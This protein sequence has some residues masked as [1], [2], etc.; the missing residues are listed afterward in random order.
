MSTE[1]W[2]QVNFSTVSKIALQRIS[3]PVSYNP[4]TTAV[5]NVP[6]SDMKTQYFHS[7]K[8]V[9]ELLLFVVDVDG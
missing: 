8:A 2:P 1:K 7:L 3:P 5:L 4:P 6:L 9:Y